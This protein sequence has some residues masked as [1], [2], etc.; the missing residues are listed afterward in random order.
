VSVT[1]AKRFLAT[2]KGGVAKGEP[3]LPRADKVTVREL[4]EDLQSEYVANER[5]S[6]KRLRSALLT[7]VLPVLGPPSGG[8]GPRPT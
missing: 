8:A 1:Q 6:A 3:I 4:A 2:C 5:R 7:H